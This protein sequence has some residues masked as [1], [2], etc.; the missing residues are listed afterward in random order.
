MVGSPQKVLKIPSA[1]FSARAVRPQS[2]GFRIIIFRAVFVDSIVAYASK[3][4]L[5][6]VAAEI[7][8]PCTKTSSIVVMIRPRAAHA[9]VRSFGARSVP[10]TA[11]IMSMSAARASSSSGAFSS[12]SSQKIIR[13]GSPRVHSPGRAGRPRSIFQL[14]SPLHSSSLRCY[15]KAARPPKHGSKI[16]KSAPETPPPVGGP[17]PPV[18]VPPPQPQHDQYSGHHQ[19]EAGQSA[20]RTVALVVASLFGTVFAISLM[21][22]MFPRRVTL[23]HKDKD[24]YQVDPATGRRL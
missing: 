13:P 19:Q 21:Q 14:P 18:G 17:P 20:W 5:C 15:S 9:V 12:F 3:S 10:S 24:G 16:K 1:N 23:I 8:P 22:R 2:L 11:P 6:S 4:I 7:H